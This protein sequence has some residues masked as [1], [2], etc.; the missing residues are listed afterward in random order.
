MTPPNKI[1][2][3]QF[4]TTEVTQLIQQ[5]RSV[6]T[7]DF[8]DEEIDKSDIDQILANAHWAP[9][10]GRTEPWH[11]VVISGA[12]RATF[13]QAHAEIYKR[14]TPETEFSEGKYQKW[15]RRPTECSHMIA[16]CVKRGSNP[17]IPVIEETNAVACAVQNMYLT[18]LSLGLVGYWTTGGMTYHPAMKDHLGLGPE[19]Q[20]LGFFMLGKPKDPEFYPKGF[21][22]VGWEEKVVWME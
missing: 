4:D 15:A 9:T 1:P 6:F 22:K 18:T 12:A 17:K 16:I 7:R 19:D 5:R 2:F 13:G 21:R 8:S 10:H 3:P 20:C 11:F 14:Y